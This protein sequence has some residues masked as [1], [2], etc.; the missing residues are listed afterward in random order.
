MLVPDDAEA[1]E[2]LVVEDSCNIQ[3]GADNS[4][5]MPDTL[6]VKRRL[7]SS[8]VALRFCTVN[9]GAMFVRRQFGFLRGW[10][11]VPTKDVLYVI[12]H[13][14]AAC[15]YTGLVVPS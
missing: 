13:F 9:D 10:V 6:A 12:V 5:D 11:T 15:A 4:L 1:D 8:P 14:K 7:C 2:E 3:Q